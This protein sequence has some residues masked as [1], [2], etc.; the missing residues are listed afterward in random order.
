MPQ[1]PRRRPTPGA[2]VPAD[3]LPARCG[4]PTQHDRQTFETACTWDRFAELHAAITTAAYDVMAALGAPGSADL[5]LHPRLPRRPRAVL[6]GS[7]L[8]AVVSPRPDVDELKAGV[9]EAI[10]THGGT[11]THHHAVGRDHVRLWLDRQRPE[12]FAAALRAAKS[13]LDPR[14]ILNPGLRPRALTGPPPPP[15]SP[16]PSRRRQRR[17]RP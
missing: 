14:G 13:A 9:S 4:R 10:A 8:R 17:R 11:I 6:R 2:V 3:A 5:P 16:P 7:C 12:P 15:P 1:H